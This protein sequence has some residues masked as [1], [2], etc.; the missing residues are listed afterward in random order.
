VRRAQRL[1][2]PLRDPAL[3]DLLVLLT[4]RFRTD[5]VDLRRELGEGVPRGVDRIGQALPRGLDEVPP[6]GGLH[7]PVNAGQEVG[8][9]DG[10]DHAVQLLD[11]VPPGD[12]SGHIA[13]DPEGADHV[14]GVDPD[15]GDHPRD[16]RDACEFTTSFDAIVAMISRLKG[17]SA[18]RWPNASTIAG[19]KYR[20]RSATRYSLSGRSVSRSARKDGALRVRAAAR[21]ARAASSR[22]RS[23]GAPPSRRSS[24][25]TRRRVPARLGL[26]LLHQVLVRLDPLRRR[27]SSCDRICA[28]R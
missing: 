24:A 26:E 1:G 6:R 9:H 11:L 25:G 4:P 20:A 18:R 10:I 2:N 8:L 15:L 5:L 19:G 3:R 7:E 14:A 23:P 27:S 13:R 21:R 16:E 22:L 12:G 17:C 28:W